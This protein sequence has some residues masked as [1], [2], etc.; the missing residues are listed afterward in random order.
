M[1]P[2]IHIKYSGWRVSRGLVGLGGWLFIDSRQN[3]GRLL[4]STR[5]MYLQNVL[6]RILTPG[7]KGQSEDYGIPQYHS[8]R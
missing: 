7:G 6:A 4:D 8:C 5:H 1:T 3:G 2:W